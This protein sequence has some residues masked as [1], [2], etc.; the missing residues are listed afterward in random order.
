MGDWRQSSY[1]SYAHHDTSYDLQLALGVATCME[2]GDPTTPTR[3]V[4]SD[5]V[6]RAYEVFY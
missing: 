6:E 2:K 3:V 1:L 5:A 4:V